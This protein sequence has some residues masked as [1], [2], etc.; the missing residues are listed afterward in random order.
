MPANF[1][2]FIRLAVSMSNKNKSKTDI[3]R[4]IAAYFYC[5]SIPFMCF[6]MYKTLAPADINPK[7]HF[8]GKI[9]KKEVK[10]YE[11]HRVDHGIHTYNRNDPYMALGLT[12]A[13][14][15]VIREYG[16]FHEKYGRN[17]PPNGFWLTTATLEVSQ[18]YGGRTHTIIWKDF[19]ND[20][21]A[22]GIEFLL[23]PGKSAEPSRHSCTVTAGNCPPIVLD[24]G[25]KVFDHYL[26]RILEKK[27]ER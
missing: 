10:F 7:Y 12:D 20:L 14:L 24:E 16:E 2:S 17:K 25:Q 26:K 9:G 18:K 19:D 13:E 6:S 27:G 15:M 11:T 21:G 8:S 3:S 4:Y 22:D 23:Y 1:I 5:L